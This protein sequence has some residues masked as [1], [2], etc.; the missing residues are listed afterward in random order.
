MNFQGKDFLVIHLFQKVI[1]LKKTEDLEF[2]MYNVPTSFIISLLSA[3]PST[4]SICPCLT[5]G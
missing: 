4:Q 2:T 3:D 5:D 1:L